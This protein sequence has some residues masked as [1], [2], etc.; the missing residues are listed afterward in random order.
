MGRQNI[1]QIAP[2]PPSLF[3]TGTTKADSRHP[4]AVTPGLSRPSHHS[5]Q[6]PQPPASLVNIATLPAATD[7]QSHVQAVTQQLSVNRVLIADRQTHDSYITSKPLQVEFWL[8][9]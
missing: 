1:S 9:I 8:Q 6:K 2:A 7:K 3:I 4:A 5:L